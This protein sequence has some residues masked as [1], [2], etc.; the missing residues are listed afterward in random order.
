MTTMHI[1]LE[2]YSSVDLFK[3]GAY[4]YAESEDF[5]VL[6]I[7]YSVDGGSVTVI[8]LKGETHDG[9][10]L[11]LMDFEILLENPE[12]K[13]MAWNASFERVCLGSHYGRY[14]PPREWICDMVNA[15]RIGLP[16]SLQKAGEV[17]NIDKAKDTA[18]KQL[19]RYFSV[20]CKPT[21]VNG[22]RT[23]NL[24]QHDPERWQQFL[25]YCKRDVEAEMEIADKI[26][27]FSVPEFEQR[28]WGLDQVINDTG[29]LL[30]T[31]LV[32]GAVELDRQAKI[33]DTERAKRLTG[34]ENP[35]S[36]QQLLGWF[37]DQGHDIK[38]VRKDTIAEIYKTG[39][40]KVKQM[41]GLRI[42]LSKTSVKKYTKM[43]DMACSDGRVRGAFQ[44]YGASKTG[45]WAG[46]GVQLQN[47]TKHKLSDTQLDIARA[48]IKEQ[49]FDT[50]D[51]IFKESP[52]NLLSQL[53]RTA[54]IAKP[55]HK[56]YVSDFSAIEA[57]VIAWY[58]K[59]QWRLQVFKTHGKI[60]EASASQMFNVPL[61][62]ISKGDPLR[63][64]GKVAE[65]ALGYQ[66]SVGALKQMGAL[67][68]GVQGDELQ[69]LVDAWR[70]A[71]PN[72]KA[73]WYGLQQAC[74]DCIETRETQYAFGLKIYMQK[75]FMMMELP[76]GRC[77]VYPKPELR[78][79]KWGG[80]AI[81][82]KGM[83]DKNKWNT[84]DT[85]GGK[86][87]ENVVQATAR[88]ILGISM[89]RLYKAGYSIVGHV[90]D[91]VI[92][93]APEGESLEGIED[94]MGREIEWAEGLPL[95]AEGFISDFYMKD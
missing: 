21:K 68:M 79:N 78:T 63:Q 20:P 1:D 80:Q 76:S 47:L 46:R 65:L 35:N 93:E 82:F 7:A 75:G 90:H 54:F 11:Q 28:L 17:L 32:A 27:G 73:F 36:Q 62:S 3:H 91:E 5:E 49:D 31:E 71:N 88:D 24:P 25:E 55:G 37:N 2:T 57:R 10:D 22:G 83:D 13:K 72:I 70:S 59:E 33:T 19:I 44:F 60:Y 9:L 87:V 45:R 56:F 85:Y 81:T 40:G 51:M 6:M 84:I 53:V 16:A 95:G 43:H 38:D 18:G 41:A 50:L 61:E 30:D 29:I 64:K 14:M 23:R 74:I 48:L 69:G 42:N 66:G 77:L 92:I 34:L 4:K 67:E 86:L 39:D 15:T 26:K 52:Q 58:A 12:V 94:I 8:D 89:M